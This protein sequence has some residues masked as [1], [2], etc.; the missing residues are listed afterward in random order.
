MASNNPKSS[1]KFLWII[2]AI[3]AFIAVKQI[4]QEWYDQKALDKAGANAEQ[5]MD[6]MRSQAA[7]ENPNNPTEALQEKLL[8]KSQEE[9][10][11]KSGDQKA[12]EAAGQYLGFY[13]INVRTRYEYCK[14]FGVNITPYVT[15]FKA[16][17]EALYQKSREIHART[18][19]SPDKIENE[20][21]KQVATSFHKTVSDDMQA[22]AKEYKMTTKEVCLAFSS[23]AQELAKAM[24]LANVN[25]ALYKAMV[26]AK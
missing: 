4:K 26:E 18:A 24:S 2:V 8:K 19:Y 15:A 13:L 21:Y 6:A 23:N 11:K 16:D 3:G 17:N 1:S 22:T 10:A 7:A 12:D 25:P 9:L 5:Q 14:A 20:L